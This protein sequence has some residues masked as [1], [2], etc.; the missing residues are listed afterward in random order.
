MC[1]DDCDSIQC[2]HLGFQV[3]YWTLQCFLSLVIAAW[4]TMQIE[5][6]GNFAEL[7]QGPEHA[8][9][10][11]VF[12]L[13]TEKELQNDTETGGGGGGGGQYWQ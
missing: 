6:G 9:N 12:I 1:C 13:T 4:V 11:L 3:F 8:E 7:N 10:T 2:Y 5:A